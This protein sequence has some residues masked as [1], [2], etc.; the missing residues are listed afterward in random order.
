[1]LD[2]IPIVHWGR[3]R[4]FRRRVLAEDNTLVEQSHRLVRPL[5]A[6][7]K[8]HPLRSVRPETIDT[9]IHDWRETLPVEFS[10]DFA[11]TRTKHGFIVTERRLSA[12]DMKD[13]DDPEIERVI[14]VSEITL[15]IDR[16]K[17]RQ[18]HAI[19]A[20]FPLRALAE[21]FRWCGYDDATLIR[22][23]DAA[24]RFDVAKIPQDHAVAIPTEGGVWHARAVRAEI[25][26]GL[27]RRLIRCH[28][29]V[30]V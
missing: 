18:D 3:A 29:W 26:P 11:C 14:S 25:E 15:A 16:N 22:A 2:H 13:D 19:Q 30:P 6:R 28:S 23:I 27:E 1:M 9:L 17:L 8:R 7:L 24:G 20:V 4:D 5:V 21:H 12:A 10:L